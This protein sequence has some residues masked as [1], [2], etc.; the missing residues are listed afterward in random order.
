MFKLVIFGLLV[1][2]W[3]NFKD[4]EGGDNL[5]KFI[6][7]A[8]IHLGLQFNNVSFN[9]EKAFARRR[10]IWQTFQKIIKKSID[11][12]VDFLLIAGDLFEW[13]YFTLGDIKRLR[14]SLSICKDVNVII[15]AGNH[16]YIDQNSLYNK[17]E[18]SE[19]VTIFNN[20][21]D[22]K[23]FKD[24]NTVVYGYSWDRIEIK[25]SEILNSFIREEE[26]KEI[27][28]IHGDISSKSNYLPLD[29]NILKDLDMDYIALGH[30][31]KH[32]FF[33]N[34][35]AYSGSPEPLDFSETGDKGII[36]GEIN[37]TG[38]KTEFVPL[39]KRQFHIKD[40][41]LNNEM[42]YGEIT[43]KIKSIKS[44]IIESDFYRI[45][46]NGYIDSDLD[47]RSLVIDLEDCFYHIE[48][49]DKTEPDFDIKALEESNVDNIVGQFI[50]TMKKEESDNPL[51]KDSLHYGLSAL[52]KGRVL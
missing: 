8:D 21:L 40:I 30:I 3:Y 44:G 41:N 15:S 4:I 17:V 2:L 14:D 10:E 11:E 25:E 33:T 49:I 38:T 27:L 28:I 29:L 43:D 19:N 13:N 32:E 16:D 31:H 9:K 5:V 48:I 47:L 36:T 51:F 45:N 34:S 22:K 52:L 24:L 7:T 26:M 46:L 18:W 12:K 6:H 42:G 35:I 23:F 39:S 1:K 37:K 20:N 50:K